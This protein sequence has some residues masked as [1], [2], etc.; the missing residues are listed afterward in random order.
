MHTSVAEIEAAA[1]ANMAAPYPD[2]K[3]WAKSLKPG[4]VARR[5][6]PKVVAAVRGGAPI[7]SAPS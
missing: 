1:I 5:E 6:I 3:K 7:I 2:E 4:L